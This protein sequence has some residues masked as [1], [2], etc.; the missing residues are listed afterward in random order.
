MLNA[1]LAQGNPTI[2]IAKP[3]AAITQPSAIHQ[4]PKTIQSRLRR[5][6]MMDMAGPRWGCEAAGASV[7]PRRGL[8]GA[9]AV[10]TRASARGGAA[11]GG[12]LE[13]LVRALKDESLNIQITG[14][15]Q[16]PQIEPLFDHLV[17][18]AKRAQE[19]RRN[20]TSTPRGLTSAVGDRHI[21]QS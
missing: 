10:G 11:G 4:P 7:Q 16:M 20:G 15:E 8:G 3:T 18:A 9:A 2:G 1:A 14:R 5:R 17:G 21:H 13:C 12:R 6:E 19:C